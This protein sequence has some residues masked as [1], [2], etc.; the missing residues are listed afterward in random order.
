MSAYET[1][2]FPTIKIELQGL[3]MQV[4]HALTRYNVDVEDHVNAALAK[5]VENF[6]FE[7]VVNETVQEVMREWVH[8]EVKDACYKAFTR[9]DW[10]TGRNEPRDELQKVVRAALV[11]ALVGDQKSE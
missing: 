7:K 10:D 1:L 11:T 9:I 8:R 5:A 4:V 3:R 2:P 6:P